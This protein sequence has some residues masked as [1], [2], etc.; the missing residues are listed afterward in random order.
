MS[1]G[2]GSGHS[3]RL[4]ILLCLAWFVSFAVYQI[5]GLFD[6]STQEI[7]CFRSI[8]RVCCYVLVSDIRK[9]E[10]QEVLVITVLPAVSCTIM[11]LKK[12]E[13][14]EKQKKNK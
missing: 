10:G 12:R 13:E 9:E 3:L 4:D 5:G 6:M 7:A 2:I 1:R 11:M 14:C 8:L